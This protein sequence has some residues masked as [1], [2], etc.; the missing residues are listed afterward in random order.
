MIV[1]V[2][3]YRI[4][5]Q[6][7]KPHK[8]FETYLGNKVFHG[9]LGWEWELSSE[10]T[11]FHKSKSRHVY[12]YKTDQN[13]ICVKFLRNTRLGFTLLGTITCHSLP[14]GTFPQVGYFIFYPC[15]IF[16]MR[17]NHQLVGIYP[18]KW[19]NT[20]WGRVPAL[21]RLEGEVGH[22]NQGGIR[23][24]ESGIHLWWVFKYC[25]EFQ[26]I[27]KSQW[28]LCFYYV[29]NLL[30]F[31]EWF[32]LVMFCLICCV[33]FWILFFFDFW[34]ILLLLLFSYFECVWN[35]VFL[36]FSFVY[37]IFWIVVLRRCGAIPLLTTCCIC[38]A[39]PPRKSPGGLPFLLG[40]S[41]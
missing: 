11:T 34:M 22:E 6:L 9:G 23:F 13:S 36:V 5:T 38:G 16:Q 35:F 26:S 2:Y 18:R 25:Q 27:Q 28:K 8:I 19:S 31:V 32:E 37:C 12:I 29:V 30:I 15:H 33:F 1:H 17:L 10:V 21:P 41:L 3:I 20:R 4:Y 24:V 40:T 7:E 39:P 14:V